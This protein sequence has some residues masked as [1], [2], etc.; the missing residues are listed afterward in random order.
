M[1][2]PRK[3]KG[4]GC[5]I[6]TTW[7][8]QPLRVVYQRIKKWFTKER[9]YAHQIN[10]H[11]LLTRLKLELSTEVGRQEVLSQH[12]SHHFNRSILEA[13][14]KRLQ[15]LNDPGYQ[16]SGMAEWLRTQFYPQI[17]AT[18]R[19]GERKSHLP[20]KFDGLL[21]SL[22]WA[23]VDRA[24]WL[25]QSGGHDELGRLVG[26]PE[27]FQDAARQTVILGL[28]Q[29]P[30]Y[31]KLRGEEK[32]FVSQAELEA[33]ATRRRLTHKLHVTPPALAKE[34][35]EA[36][37]QHVEEHPEQTLQQFQLVS[38]GGGDK[39]RLTLITIQTIH[40][41]LDPEATPRGQMPKQILIVPSQ[42]HARLENID[43]AGKWVQ[44][45]RRPNHPHLSPPEFQASRPNFINHPE[46]TKRPNPQV[47][48]KMATCREIYN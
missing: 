11:H 17:G 5:S 35:V 30:V 38:Q 20:E 45:A 6:R 12:Q 15:R 29:T 39:Y 4:Q 1:P 2:P 8:I 14:Q 47:G 22:T 40:G 21:A 7:K 9:Q 28:D 46:A 10:S 18:P 41:L 43:Q 44:T 42:T 13:C 37:H 32:V 36:L 26:N 16:T 27:A 48:Q 25:A 24:L 31:L 3:N 34:A 19:S 23:S 33:R